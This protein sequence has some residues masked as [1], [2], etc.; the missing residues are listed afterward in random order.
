MTDNQP[1]PK[2]RLTVMKTQTSPKQAASKVTVKESLERARALIQEK[3]RAVRHYEED[4][5]L[6]I[7]G[8]VMHA[9]GYTKHEGYTPVYSDERFVEAKRLLEA[10]LPQGYNGT[11]DT[12]NAGRL[13]DEEL[14]G[15]FERA[16][17]KAG[18]SK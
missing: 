14:D 16:I 4:G 2:R 12:Y 9:L 11:L 18:G 15:L 7:L 10:A 5:R 6:C 13:R 8:A 17:A 3:G 1:S